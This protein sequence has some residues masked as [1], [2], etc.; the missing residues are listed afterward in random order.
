[1][2]HVD[3]FNLFYG[4]AK[5]LNM[6]LTEKM[7]A[8]AQKKQTHCTHYYWQQHS[9][10]ASFIIVV[11]DRPNHHT[12]CKAA[13]AVAMETCFLSLCVQV[14]DFGFAKRVR[15]RTWTLC[16]TPEYLAPEI[17][18][19]KV[20]W[21]KQMAGSVHMCVI[22]F[23]AAVNPTV[24]YSLGTRTKLFGNIPTPRFL[25]IAC[26][27]LFHSLKAWNSVTWD[28]EN[29]VDHRHGLQGALASGK[30][31]IRPSLSLAIAYV[32]AWAVLFHET[33]NAIFTFCVGLRKLVL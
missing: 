27:F 21:Y 23:Y 32:L 10:S 9:E 7:A 2:H 14:T 20:R 19:S 11:V 26:C 15:G 6:P 29:M 13:A 8:A 5:F 31:K 17:I 22:G 4:G 24:R 33:D 3:I 1:M 30:A 16:G 18:L 12:L 28:I 25:R